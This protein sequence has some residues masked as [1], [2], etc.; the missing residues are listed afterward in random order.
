[1]T[2][3]TRTLSVDGVGPVEVTFDDDGEGAPFLLLH[4][5]GGPD[6]MAPFARQ[7]TQ[8][9]PARVLVPTHPGF[10]GTPRPER[11]DSIGHLATLYVTLLDDLGLSH[12]TVVGNSIGGWVTVEMALGRSPR[13]GG[14]VLV[15]A[16]GI[17]VP[18]QPVADF[19]TTSYDEFLER[20]FHDPEAFRVDLASLP[21]AAQ[22][23]A[24]AN[25]A[26]LATYTGGAMNDPSLAARLAD[27]GIPAVVLWG[28]SDRIASPEYG[29]AYAA[30][31]PGARFEV[32]ADAGHL[33]QL[34]RPDAV[35]GAIWS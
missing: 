3:V 20:A 25:R 1:M 5:G 17:D 4:G 33:P 15:D 13:I 12:V 6:T 7:F 28:D 26:A 29:R 11:L 34:E 23:T 22:A 9:H 2:G 8:T 31:I 14:I 32:L 24:A 35:L 19:F 18:D 30:S 10:A 16:V 27:V 21:P